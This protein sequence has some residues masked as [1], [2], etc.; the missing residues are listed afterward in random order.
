MST[1]VLGLGPAGVVVAVPMCAGVV[2]LV[3]AVVAVARR[4]GRLRVI[5]AKE[6]VCRL[7]LTRVLEAG[8]V[9]RIVVGRVAKLRA[10]AGQRSRRLAV[11]AVVAMAM[12]AV[13]GCGVVAAAVAAAVM[14]PVAVAMT[15][16]VAILGGKRQI[17]GAAVRVALV[18]AAER[19]AV[20]PLRFAEVPVLVQPRIAPARPR[21]AGRHNNDRLVPRH[22]RQCCRKLV[23]LLQHGA[24]SLLLGGGLEGGGEIERVSVGKWASNCFLMSNETNIF[25]IA[26]AAGGAVALGR[27]GT[28][29]HMEVRQVRDDW[30]AGWLRLCLTC[31]S[32]R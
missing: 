23:A 10:R 15:A 3:A 2:M 7:P 14:V 11:M 27:A 26:G 16:V 4:T 18:L 30:V 25:V 9:L 21:V 20:A 29:K 24:F 5:V 8:G 31:R 19:A 17:L 28:E 22:H 6:A 13:G 32:Y 1:L 12:V